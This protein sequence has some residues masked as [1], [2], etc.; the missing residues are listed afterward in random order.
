MYR[1]LRNPARLLRICLTLARYDA[2]FPLERV[3]LA[4][5]VVRLARLLR[6]RRLQRRSMRKF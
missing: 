6:R 3:G 1:T 2:L 5:F 4:P